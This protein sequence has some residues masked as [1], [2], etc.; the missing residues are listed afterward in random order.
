MA[1]MKAK[2]GRG[3]RRDVRAVDALPVAKD[4]G[5][6]S[7]AKGCGGGGKGRKK[8]GAG[9]SMGKGGTS[10]GALGEGSDKAV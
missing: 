6:R 4:A 3:D 10:E 5:R 8:A 1:T 7:K 9:E 2:F